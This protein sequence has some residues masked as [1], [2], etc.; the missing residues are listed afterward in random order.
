MKKCATSHSHLLLND[1]HVGKIPCNKC[2]L[3]KKCIKLVEI[4]WTT[5]NAGHF[6]HSPY[7]IL[8]LNSTLSSKAIYF[9]CQFN[10]VK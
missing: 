3:K 7:H 4:C 9:S 8:L 6:T 2:L 10:I 1:I 5:R